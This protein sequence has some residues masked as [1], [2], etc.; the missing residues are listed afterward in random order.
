MKQNSDLDFSHCFSEKTELINTL[1]ELASAGSFVFRGY[2]TQDQLLPSIIRGGKNGDF[3]EVENELL[4]DFEK[5]GSHYFFANTPIDFM[6]YGQHYGLPTRLLD[7]T[8][9]PFIALRFALFSAKSSG[10]YTKN[11]EDADYYYIR[12]CKIDENIHLKSLPIYRA[13][14]LGNFESD[15]MAKKCSSALKIYSSCLSDPTSK[16]FPSY[17]YGLYDC[18]YFPGENFEKYKLEI[19]LKIQSRKLCFIDPSQSN[20]RIIMQQGLFMVPYTLNKEVHYGLIEKNTSVIKIHKSLR[21]PLLM[22]LDTLGY[23]AFRLMPD[24]AS[25]CEAVKQKIKDERSISSEL[26]KKKFID[27]SDH[28]RIRSTKNGYSFDVIA[29][30]R[31]ILATSGVYDTLDSCKEGIVSAYESF[32][33]P[34][35]DQTELPF[36][37]I[38]S[39]KY[40]LYTDEAGEFRF[41]LKS[42]GDGICLTSEGYKTKKSCLNSIASIKNLESS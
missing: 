23:N 2:N 13:F 28:I 36:N 41:R 15:S 9:N 33:S 22:Y 21:E 6:S 24:L 32:S 42:E 3:A 38:D 34:I 17:L 18:D 1:S 10:K 40:E 20:Q 37:G 19:T 7:F 16:S 14:T 26:F 39:P 27:E 8:Y 31:Q 12:F 25:V 35:E 29:K 5:F 11:P 30:N 4:G